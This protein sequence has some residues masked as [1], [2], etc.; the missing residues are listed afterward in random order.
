M[1]SDDQSNT[2]RIDCDIG[3]SSEGYF[4]GRKQGVAAQALHL[5]R[6]EFDVENDLTYSNLLFK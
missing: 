6:P 3:T 5:S 2:G 1:V 4:F